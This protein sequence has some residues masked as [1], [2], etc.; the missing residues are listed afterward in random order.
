MRNNIVRAGKTS[1]SWDKLGSIY[2]STSMR[3][4]V[5]GGGRWYLSLIVRRVSTMRGMYVCNIGNIET[6]LCIRAAVLCIVTY[7]VYVKG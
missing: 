7:V 2:C 4:Y 5:V 6:A 3:R 1:P